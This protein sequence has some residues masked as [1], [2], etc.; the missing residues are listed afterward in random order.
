MDFYI[1][2]VILGAFFFII[3]FINFSLALQCYN[4]T[5]TR[6]YDNVIEGNCSKEAWNVITCSSSENRCIRALMT[7]SIYTRISF[8]CGHTTSCGFNSTIS[9]AI[10]NCTDCRTDLCNSSSKHFSFFQLVIIVTLFAIKFS[11]G[12][13]QN[14]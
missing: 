12:S 10:F 4:C 5:E 14:F 9:E 8:G 7:N 2:F 13:E 6:R 3:N 1:K 11:L